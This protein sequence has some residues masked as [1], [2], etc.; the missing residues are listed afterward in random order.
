MAAYTYAQPQ[1]VQQNILV[2]PVNGEVGAATYPVGAGNTVLLMDWNTH[3]FWIKSTDMSGVPQAMR[4]FTFDEV[5]PPRK[6]AED[7]KEL[8]EK[9]A[10]LKAML[11]NIAKSPIEQ[12]GTVAK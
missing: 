2:V 5:T 9:F 12:A 8:K 6:D 7:I 10:E 4:S 3:Q 1:Q 11:Q